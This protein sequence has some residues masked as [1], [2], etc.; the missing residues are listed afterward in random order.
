MEV[1]VCFASLLTSGEDH[2]WLDLLALGNNGNK[3]KV[4]FVMFSLYGCVMVVF[5]K[6]SWKYMK[7]M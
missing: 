2:D 7:S 6:R 3:H 5:G 4:V 1:R